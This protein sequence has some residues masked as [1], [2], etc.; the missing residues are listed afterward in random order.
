MPKNGQTTDEETRQTSDRLLWPVHL[1]GEDVSLRED[2]SS[3]LAPASEV[4][5]GHTL[6]KKTR[7]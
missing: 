1:L 5:G 3:R 7:A 6:Q 2:A 4:A